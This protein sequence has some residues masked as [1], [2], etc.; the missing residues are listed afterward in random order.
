VKVPRLQRASSCARD[1]P[2]ADR[3]SEVATFDAQA[4]T[5][6]G[7]VVSLR[8]IAQGKDWSFDMGRNPRTMTLMAHDG[9]LVPQ[10][11]WMRTGTAVT[12][13]N[14]MTH[15]QLEFKAWFT[16]PTAT[17]RLVLKFDVMVSA[18]QTTSPSDDTVLSKAGLYT[19]EC[20]CPGLEHMRA[21]VLAFDHPYVDGPTGID[22][23][24]V[25]EDVPPGEYEVVCWHGPFT[26]ETKDQGEGRVGY[27]YGAPVESVQKVTVPS[28]GHVTVDFVLEPPR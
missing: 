9:V 27:E 16:K 7:C 24:Y 10:V 23:R 15:T 12:F 5:L 11:R 19:V 22:G 8:Q 20:Y 28:R 17:S 26:L 4:L 3:P 1:V 2:W 18:G 6:K 25:L 13:A 14:E 21:Q